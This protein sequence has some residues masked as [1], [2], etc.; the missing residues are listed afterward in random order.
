MKINQKF[1]TTY[2]KLNLLKSLSISMHNFNNTKKR[3]VNILKVL[4]LIE[5]T[6]KKH[7]LHLTIIILRQ[8]LKKMISNQIDGKS[9]CFLCKNEVEDC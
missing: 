5:V 7:K 4:G 6:G 9:N 8:P 1:R 3:F 2:S